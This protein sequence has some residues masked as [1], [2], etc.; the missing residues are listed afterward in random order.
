MPA[1][2]NKIILQYNA[3]E[4]DHH[5]LM[6]DKKTMLSEQMIEYLNSLFEKGVF[7]Y[8]PIIKFL[9]E[10]RTNHGIFLNE[11]NPEFRQVE[12]RLSKWRNTNIKPMIKLG[13][14]M[15]W[16]NA[17]SAYP[18]D[19][20]EAFI[21]NVPFQFAML[22]TVFLSQLSSISCVSHMLFAILEKDHLL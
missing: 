12:Y 4:H 10:H 13:D 20:N 11:P 19:D 3:N 6:K 5:E 16:C 21:L 22:F 18:T 15:E 7:G 2:S 9:E 17:N 8:D 1:N 14:L